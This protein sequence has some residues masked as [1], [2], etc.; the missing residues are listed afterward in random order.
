MNVSHWF[1]PY[2]K[3]RGTTKWKPHRTA[4]IV[5]GLEI[6]RRVIE[7]HRRKV[8]KCRRYELEK[9]RGP[10]GGGVPVACIEWGPTPP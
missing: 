7:S 5:M 4:Y 6:E 9:K 10:T 2:C 1:C 8:K 3:T